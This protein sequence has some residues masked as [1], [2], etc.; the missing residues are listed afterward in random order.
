MLEIISHGETYGYE[1]TQKL[2]QYGFTDIVEGTVY[3]VTMRLEK[4]HL[5]DVKKEPSPKGPPRKLYTLNDE[6][7]RQ[8]EL[9][10]CKWDFIS[11]RVKEL[12]NM[13]QE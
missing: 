7:K 13:R 2:H 12:R 11:D 1:I 10:W 4:N 6:G 9:F 5:V 8:L 3:T